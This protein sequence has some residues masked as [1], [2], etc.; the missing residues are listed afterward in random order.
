VRLGE[1]HVQRYESRLRPEAKQGEQESDSGPV[2][3]EMG[4]AHRIEGELPAPALHDPEAEQN[5][6]G[7]HVRD[8]QVKKPCTAD[9]GQAVLSGHEEVGR[10]RHGLPRHHEC[11]GVVRQEYQAHAGQKQVVLQAHQSGCGS[12]ATAEVASREDGNSRGG[13]TQQDE[14]EARERITAHM[15]RQIRQAHHEDRVLGGR[16]DA[17]RGHHCK[18]HTAQGPERK[19]HPT[20]KAEAR[21]TQQTCDPNQ[22]PK[23]QEREAGAQR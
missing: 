5:G 6:E 14:K 11:V 3:S 23:R 17:R 8:Q 4:A 10:Q 15:H 22:G 16:S 13:G 20:D 18:R 1:P 12:R 21:R 19:E 7:P 2:R 9:L